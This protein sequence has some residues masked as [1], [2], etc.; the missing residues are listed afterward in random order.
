MITNDASCISEIKSGANMATEA[1][2]NKRLFSSANW[3]YVYGR[4]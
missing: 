1:F 3:S 2:K 4:N